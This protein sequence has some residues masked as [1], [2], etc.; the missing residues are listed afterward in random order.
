MLTEAVGIAL[1]EAVSQLTKL[2]SLSM[3]EVD[4]GNAPHI[5]DSL[6]VLPMGLL[7]RFKH[8]TALRLNDMWIGTP[9]AATPVL[10]PLQALTARLGAAAFE[11]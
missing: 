4:F 11:A 6:L 7:E 9:E 1:L 3:S 2:E 5:Q 10:Q 8:L